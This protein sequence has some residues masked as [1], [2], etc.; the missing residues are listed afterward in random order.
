VTPVNFAARR[1]KSSSILSVVLMCISMY[2]L[3]ISVKRILL[4]QRVAFKL[5]TRC[6]GPRPARTVTPQ[7][8]SFKRLILI[9]ASS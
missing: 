2:Q 5:R 8:D 6:H 4:S 7:G 9:E 1:S 3:C